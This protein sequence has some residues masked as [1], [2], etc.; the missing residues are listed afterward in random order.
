MVGGH[1]ADRLHGGNGDDLLI[2]GASWALTLENDAAARDA[3]LSTWR[4]A[5]NYATKIQKLRIDGVGPDASIKLSDGAA[6]SDDFLVDT[7][8]GNS[9]LDWFV[10]NTSTELNLASGGLRDL[11]NN[12]QYSD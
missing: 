9:G 11:A 4:S 5:D 1:G 2:G 3:V 12:E 7:F 10:L 6:V 8:F